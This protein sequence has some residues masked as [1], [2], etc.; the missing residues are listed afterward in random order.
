MDFLKIYGVEIVLSGLGVEITPLIRY[1]A[2]EATAVNFSFSLCQTGEKKR[3]Q[4]IDSSNGKIVKGRGFTTFATLDD[5]REEITIISE[6]NGEK[7]LFQFFY[8]QGEV[9]PA[10]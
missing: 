10:F 1:L 3:T 2:T 9:Y 8:R 6:V 5:L 7:S 4:V